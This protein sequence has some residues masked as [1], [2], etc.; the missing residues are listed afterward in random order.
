MAFQSQGIK[1]DVGLKLFKAYFDSMP[2]LFGSIL[3]MSC[4]YLR[5][6]M[7]YYGEFWTKARSKAFC[8]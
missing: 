3:T 8:I 6:L 1:Y 4:L 2:F 7:I 5:N